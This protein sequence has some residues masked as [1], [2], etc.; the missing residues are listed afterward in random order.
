[1]LEVAQNLRAKRLVLMGREG[2]ELKTRHIDYKRKQTQKHK[3]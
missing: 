2:S 3:S 1:M